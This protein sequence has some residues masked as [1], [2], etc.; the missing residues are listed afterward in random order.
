MV[1]VGFIVV[2]STEAIVIESLQFK[3]WLI[4]QNIELVKPV[5]DACGSGNLLPKYIESMVAQLNAASAEHI[6]ILTDLE[7]APVVEVV[8]QR[9]ANQHTNLIFV[10]VKAIEAWFLADTQA[11][12]KWLKMTDFDELLPEQ[13]PDL[14][15]DR[16]K[17][18]TNDLDKRGPG[19]NK[20]K[21]AKQMV[22]HHGF[23]VPN[24]AQHP[25]CPSATDFINGLISLSQPSNSSS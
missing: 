1:K 2:G 5:L 16:L 23:A 4:A 14:P 15:W 21:F 13:T 24:A 19:N 9:I 25:N 22:K 20:V 3:Q 17:D 10:A 8:R 12:N 11:M 7:D 6:V 18:I